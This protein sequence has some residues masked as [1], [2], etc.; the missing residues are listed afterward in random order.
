MNVFE[1]EK[2]ASST[3]DVAERNISADV[4]AV[5]DLYLYLLYQHAGVVDQWR[6]FFTSIPLILESS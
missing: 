1:I 3:G 5:F 2:T 4:R 6:T